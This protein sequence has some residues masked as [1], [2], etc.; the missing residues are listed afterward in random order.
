MGSFKMRAITGEP[1]SLTAKTTTSK[2]FTDGTWHT[3]QYEERRMRDSEGRERSKLLD[4]SGRPISVRLTDPVAQTIINLQPF[5][6]SAIITHIP[7]PSPDQQARAEEFRAKAAAYRAQHPPSPDTENPLPPQTIA[8]VQ[9]EGKRRFNV[10]SAKMSDGQE[11]SVVEETWTAPDLRIPLAQTSDDPR[12]EK[13]SITVTEWQ[14]AE[15]AS[16]LFQVPPNYK[17]IEQK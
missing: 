5:V 3:T 8:G 7:L 1:Y 2:K 6:K 10:L 9:T 11:V 15:P 14:R 16:A 4:A 12:G 13:I 17:L